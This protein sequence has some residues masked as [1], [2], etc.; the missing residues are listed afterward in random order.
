MRRILSKV[1]FSSFYDPIILLVYFIGLFPGRPSH[2]GEFMT[3]LM[4]QGESAATWSPLYFRLL[5]VLTFNGRILAVASVFGLL[6]LYLS[7][8]F[9]ISTLDFSAEVKFRTR[10][11]II[12]L[13]LFGFF[14]LTVNHD[15][16]AISGILIL[17]GLLFEG[18][19]T[20]PTKSYNRLI[21][22]AAILC[23]MSWLGIASF[24]GFLFSLLL[25]KRIRLATVSA[26]SMLVF[27][28][29]CAA[30]LQVDAGP[31]NRWLPMVGDVKCVVQDPD[32][33]VSEDQWDYLI[34][35]AP[36]SEWLSTASCEIADWAP[37]TAEKIFGKNPG[38]SLRT[39]L[40]L[41][42]S[43][44][45]IV[46]EAHLQR[47]AVALPPFFSAPAPN[48]YS[49]NFL[50]PVGAGLPANLFQF[51][52]FLNTARDTG[53]YEKSPSIFKPLEVTLISYAYLFNRASSF[54]G[55]GG[56]WI[57]VA[58]SLQVFYLKRPK[59]LA[60]LPLLFSHLLLLIASP[61]PISR[62]V[63]GSILVGLVFLIATVLSQFKRIPG[64]S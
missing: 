3:D 50:A 36:K 30:F 1:K 5:Q 15:V 62:Y 27:F 22:L 17:T 32:S 10:I 29:S 40:E 35:L 46:I 56:L 26:M 59:F 47:A 21:A 23:S 53:R 60:F 13:P 43:N 11:V 33:T 8:R 48:T 28:L 42:K 54:W 63:F 31:S 38:K 45:K 64:T 2:D 39:W 55:W 18:S 19:G 51:S 49:T 4:K 61:G 20:L 24:I 12:S 9:L 14:G 57:L 25:K 58:I 52:E 34:T 37:D 44:Q 41:T 6:S 16:F 7:L